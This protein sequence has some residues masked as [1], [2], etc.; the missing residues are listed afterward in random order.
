MRKASVFACRQGGCRRHLHLER[1]ASISR[2]RAVHFP[3]RGISRRLNAH[4]LSQS[5]PPLPAFA[6]YLGNTFAGGYIYMRG[7]GLVIGEPAV[8]AAEFIAT[9]SAVPV[10]DGQE[11]KRGEIVSHISSQYMSE[12]RAKLASDYARASRLAEV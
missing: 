2:A 8:V 5:P 1:G 7:E 4:F 9:V 11:V 10:K 6:V 3:A 12:T